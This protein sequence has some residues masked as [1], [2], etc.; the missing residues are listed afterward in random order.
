MMNVCVIFLHIS[1]TQVCVSIVFLFTYHLNDGGWQ[2]VGDAM[3]P[4]A[5]GW[6]RRWRYVGEGVLAY[7]LALEL[8]SEVCKW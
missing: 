7:T 1:I 3:W 6:R 4:V 8:N 5:R 2:C